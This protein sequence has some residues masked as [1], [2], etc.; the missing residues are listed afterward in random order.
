MRTRISEID[1]LRFLA[2]VAVM[3][4]HYF[5]RG[6][7]A[8]DNFSPIHFPEFGALTRYNYLAVNL[9][10]MISGFMILMSVHLQSTIYNLQST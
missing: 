10:F 1:L 3:L 9:F 2:A 5:L 7:A 4:M 6:F 8:N